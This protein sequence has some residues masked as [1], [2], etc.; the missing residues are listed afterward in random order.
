MVTAPQPAA[1]NPALHDLLSTTITLRQEITAESEE[2]LNEERTL[3][4]R[5]DYLASA[6]NLACYLALR[7][8]DLRDLQATLMQFGLSSLGRCES[9][10]LPTLDA[11]ITSLAAI[12][13]QDEPAPPGYA[14]A[15]EFFYGA[16]QIA[17]QADEILGTGPNGRY[18]RIMV[19]LPSEAAAEPQLLQALVEAGIECV[20]INCA[21]DDAARWAAMIANLRRAEAHSNRTQRVR[22]LMDLAGPKVRTIVP[23]EQKKVRVT[24]GDHLLLA[25]DPK[26]AAQQEE[27]PVIGCTLAE[28][29]DQLRVGARVWIDDGQIGLQVAELTSAG[30]LLQVLQ[31]PLKGKR[32]RPD[33]GLNFPDSDLAVAPLTAKD[34]QDLAFVAHHADLIGY[35]FVQSAGDVALLQEALAQLLGADQPLP[36][37]VLKIETHRAVRNLPQIMLRAAGRQPTAVMIARGDLAVE[38]GYERIAE[39]QEEILWLCEAAHLPV[40][41]ATQVLEQLAKEGLPTRAEVSDAALS[42]RAECV[43]LNKGP[44]IV[45]AVAL[46][47]DVLRRM[48]AHQVKKTPQLRALRAWKELFGSE[49]EE[50]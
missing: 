20:R 14:P 28:V 23:K 13:R 21:H 32:I 41:W 39:M 26:A 30:A 33:K 18:T 11:V 2:L 24:I 15:V 17:R 12:S 47:D 3:I 50:E 22:V 8:R 48:Q 5:T 46:L 37:L 38:L 34:R 4:V 10:V 29:H 40:I 43:M 42:N 45:Q 49:Q 36:A 6:R 7:R 1:T 16:D 19:T 27:L 31:A 44:F 35:S 25:R 9:R